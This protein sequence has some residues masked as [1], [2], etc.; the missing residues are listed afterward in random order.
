MENMF[1]NTGKVKNERQFIRYFKLL[2]FLPQDLVKSGLGS[3]EKH[4]ILPVAIFPEYKHESWNIIVVE[5]KAHY[6]LH[7]LLFKS[8][9]D[10]SCIY[11]F[12]Q[13]RRV[14][15][16]RG[17]TNCRLYQAV[18]IEFAKLI[19]ENNTGKVRTQ[20]QRDYMSKLFADTNIY[21]H[22]ITKELLR[23]SIGS[24]S[25]EW[26]PFQT[27]R[28][29]TQESK[30]LCSRNFTGK[31]WQYNPKTREVAQMHE[32]LPGFVK[33]YPDWLKHTDYSY[34]T[35][36]RWVSNNTTGETLR[37]NENAPRPEGFIE[38]R[39]F[40][41]KGFATANNPNNKRVLDIRDKKFKLIGK[42]D[43]SNTYY[44]VAGTSLEKVIVAN[45]E[46]YYFLLGDFLKYMKSRC[47]LQNHSP[48][49]LSILNFVIPGTTKRKFAERIRFSEIYGG[50]TLK[51]IGVVMMPLSEYNYNKDHIWWK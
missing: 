11:S 3:V 40:K 14:S 46:N 47:A 43:F 5:P 2:K 7:Y 13:M 51:E 26:E 44:R 18:R 9:R 23:M 22:K 41:N 1:R 10:R 39:I 21:R 15:K 49:D 36:S 33:G 31:I 27:G 35:E 32:I 20:E 4:H 38:G 34:I 30:D 28:V 17:I 48:R 19:S 50:K 8:I 24:Q 6:L 12:N 29:R 45:F 16:S 42:K 37:I 25:D